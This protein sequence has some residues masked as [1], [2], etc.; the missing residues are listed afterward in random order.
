MSSEIKQDENGRHDGFSAKSLPNVRAR[1]NAAFSC[2]LV[3]L[4]AVLRRSVVSPHSLAEGTTC[5]AFPVRKD[6]PPDC[7]YCPR[8]SWQETVVKCGRGRRSAYYC[9]TL[10]LNFPPTL[11]LV[12]RIAHRRM[13]AFI[14]IASQAFAL[15]FP[16]DQASDYRVDSM[17]CAQ[18]A[19]AMASGAHSRRID[20]ISRRAGPGVINSRP[21]RQQLRLCVTLSQR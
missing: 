1:Q 10:S 18:G 14:H 17:S 4:V 2:E 13:P 19:F 16:I 12:I 8:R 20:G 5:L 15:C 11:M 3:K 9:R 21:R 7:T 6:F